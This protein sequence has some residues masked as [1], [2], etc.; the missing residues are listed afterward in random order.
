MGPAGGQGCLPPGHGAGQGRRRRGRAHA[1]GLVLRRS[2][3]RRVRSRCSTTRSTSCSPTRTRSCSL[4]E[5]DDFDAAVDRAPRR[6]ARSSSVTRGAEGSMVVARRRAP[7]RPRRAIV[8]A[9]RRHHRRRRPVR[10]RLPVRPHA[11]LRPRPVRPPRPTSAAAEVISHLG[12]RPAH[13]PRRARCA[14]NSA[15]SSD[16]WTLIRL[17]GGQMSRSRDRASLRE[18]RHTAGWTRAALYSAAD[19]LPRLGTPAGSLGRSC[20]C[21]VLWSRSPAFVGG[22]LSRS[23]DSHRAS[24]LIVEGWAYH[25][26]SGGIGCCGADQARAG[27][28]GYDVNGVAWRDLSEAGAPW[29]EGDGGAADV[30]RRDPRRACPLGL[31]QLLLGRRRSE[32]A[33]RVWLECL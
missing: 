25:G 23:P 3:P 29:H 33:A 20:W 30:S 17:P 10:R 31:R 26:A 1:V 8:G 18:M 19:G 15:N 24:P 16:F 6:C 9:R 21:C 4:Y 7:C 28:D 22:R 13:L 5:V 2:L 27:G 14:R 11:R 32:R 12:P